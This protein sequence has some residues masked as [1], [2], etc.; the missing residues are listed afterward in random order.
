MRYDSTRLAGSSPASVKSRRGQMDGGFLLLVLVLL[1]MGVIMVLSSSYPRAYYDPGKVTGGKALYYFLRQLV[2]ALL[3]VGLMLLLS[4]LPMS[5]Y[6]RW[7]YPFLGITL[8]LLALVPLI[9]VK[10]NGS[11]RWL[12]VGSLTVQPSELAKLAVILCFSAMICRFREKMRSFRWGI[13]PFLGLL[14]MIVG[15][16]VL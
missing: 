15:L 4:R 7:A 12:G 6:R 2:F 11:R 8:L 10:A 13:L 3:G 9:G 5:F 16:L 14:G 1:L